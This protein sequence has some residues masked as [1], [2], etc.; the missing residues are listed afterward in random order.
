MNEIL[1]VST[2]Q[3]PGFDEELA[4]VYRVHKCPPEGPVPAEARNVRALVTSGTNG[5]PAALLAQLPAL[6]IIACVGVGYDA[7]DIPAA[8]GRRIAIT[9]TPDVLTDDVADLAIALMTMAARQLAWGDRTV[10]AGGWKTKAS[11][12]GAK[13]TGK[14]LGILGLGRIGRA[15]ARRAEAM[16]MAISYT[17]RNKADVPYR[18]IPDIVSLAR[19]S[20]FLVLAASAG[21]QTRNIVNRAVLDALGPKGVLVNVARGSLVDEPEMVLALQEGRLG[22]AAL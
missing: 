14:R 21:P 7:I 19:E 12:L 15:I 20:D 2:L 1:N 17:N 13:V 4:K 22:G 8:T 5:A 18:F 9:N 6:E 10:R 11:P 16:D 3:V